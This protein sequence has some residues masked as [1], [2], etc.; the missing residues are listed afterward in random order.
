MEQNTKMMGQM[1]TDQNQK[2]DMGNYWLYELG[3]VLDGNLPNELSLMTTYL[4][5]GIL[6]DKLSLDLLVKGINMMCL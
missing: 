2:L 3:V 5:N 1:F 6:L 4:M